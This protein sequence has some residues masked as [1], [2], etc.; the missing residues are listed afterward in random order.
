MIYI[1]FLC[2]VPQSIDF[3]EFINTLGNDDYKIYLCIDDNSYKLHNKY[4]NISTIQIDNEECSGA[5]YKSVVGYFYKKSCSKDKALYYFNTID[6]DYEYLW[7]IE[8][9]AFVPSKNTIKYIDKK[10]KNKYIDYLTPPLDKIDLNNWYWKNL[11]KSQFDLLQKNNNNKY[12]LLFDYKKQNIKHKAMT[13]AI[14]LSKKYMNTV[15]NFVNTFNTLFMDEIFFINIAI[16][17]K[18]HFKDIDELKYVIW[19]MLRNCNTKNILPT[20]IYHPVKDFEIQKLKRITS[21]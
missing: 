12:K 7:L 11:V 18:L 8:D 20:H 4:D 2:K 16:L 17:N 5:G 1:C 13:C 15:H 14:R 9:D 10:Y 19:F 3:L 21:F 6:L